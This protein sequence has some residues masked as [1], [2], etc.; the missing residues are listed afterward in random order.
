MEFWGQDS[1]DRRNDPQVQTI[2]RMDEGQEMMW[3]LIFQMALCSAF[4]AGLTFFW[5]LIIRDANR[6]SR[7]ER[8]NKDKLARR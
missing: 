1:K 4:V 2:Q 3:E 5:V 6:M 7:I 8:Q